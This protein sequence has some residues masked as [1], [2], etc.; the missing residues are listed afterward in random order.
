MKTSS[1]PASSRWLRRVCGL[2]TCGAV[3]LGGC[4]RYQPV[5]SVTP[6]PGARV[7]AD[8]TAGGTDSLSTYLGRDVVTVDGRIVRPETDTLDLSV[9]DV[10]AA[11]GQV[12]YWRGE[13]VLIPRPL[14]SRLSER[15]LAGGSTAL[16]VGGAAGLLVAA[17]E[18]FSHGPSGASGGQPPP[19]PK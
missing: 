15:R 11:N 12:T 5:S 7:S 19:V 6:V 9:I 10:R 3:I 13:D 17:I 2:L 18:G 14:I 16:L 4:Y 8:L 1:G